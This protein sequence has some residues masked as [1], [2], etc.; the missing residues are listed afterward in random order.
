MTLITMLAFLTCTI[1]VLGFACWDLDMEVPVLY[2]FG[3]FEAD[4]WF[5]DQLKPGKPHLEN[6]VKDGPPLVAKAGTGG[7]VP[8]PYPE[9]LKSTGSITTNWDAK[10]KIDQKYT[11]V[12]GLY[13]VTNQKE[14]DGSLNLQYYPNASNPNDYIAQRL[15]GPQA[16]WTELEQMADAKIFNLSVFKEGTPFGAA[17]IGSGQMDSDK[18]DEKP[19]YTAPGGAYAFMPPLTSTGANRVSFPPPNTYYVR[20][21]ADYS[22][23]EYDGS[24]QSFPKSKEAQFA[25]GFRAPTNY[26]EDQSGNRFQYDQKQI[27]A[28][29]GEYPDS[30]TFAGGT[31][32]APQN[33]I[34]PTFYD[35]QFEGSTMELGNGSYVTPVSWG[36]PNATTIQG[37]NTP[38]IQT[39]YILS[40][41]SQ[42]N[43]IPKMKRVKEGDRVAIDPKENF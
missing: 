37:Y 22:G 41:L 38:A 35:S 9:G 5:H 15:L 19:V 32:Q 39:D 28:W 17:E 16:D 13:G 7:A 26:Q 2:R 34:L 29:A 31:P 20:S 10:I 4:W 21:I 40:Q 42:E 27:S 6:H 3:K 24:N 36:S 18:W 12:N 43:P 30:N 23:A 8:W 25:L 14:T 33:Y 11:P 1:G